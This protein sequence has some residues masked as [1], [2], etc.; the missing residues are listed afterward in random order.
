VPTLTELGVTGADEP[1]WYCT[2]APKGTPASI[3]NKMNAKMLEITATDDMKQRM[4]EIS[5]D[6]PPQRPEEIAAFMKNDFATNAELIKIAKVKL[7]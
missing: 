3:I 7:E 5:A 6:V 4:R 1:L 2:F